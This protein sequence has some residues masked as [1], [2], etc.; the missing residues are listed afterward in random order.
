MDVALKDKENN[1]SNVHE[2]ENTC[3][4]T[5]EEE[6]VG[7]SE[8]KKWLQEQAFAKNHKQSDINNIL[9]QRNSVTNELTQDK[10]KWLQEQAFAKKNNQHTSD[11]SQS[12][13]VSR[14]LTQ[15][16]VKWLQEQAF[17]KI[18]KDNSSTESISHELTQDKVK[19]LQEQAFAK[20][21]TIDVQNQLMS[22]E[23]T[24]DKVKWLQ[25]QAFVSKQHKDE[26][27]SNVSHELTQDKVKW[28]Q[29]EAFGKKD[30]EILEQNTAT[31]SHELTQD[32]VKWLQEKAF[33]NDRRDNDKIHNVLE[34]TS[35]V[36]EINDKDDEDDNDD[37]EDV[38]DEIDEEDTVYE[39]LNDDESSYVDNAD[40]FKDVDNADDINLDGRE[41]NKDLYALLS[42]SKARLAATKEKYLDNDDNDDNDVS[43]DDDSESDCFDDVLSE[44]GISKTC[45]ETLTLVEEDSS[46]TN[47][48]MDNHLEE[49]KADNDSLS[50]P[51]MGQGNYAEI[52]DQP[53]EKHEK[54]KMTN[55]EIRREKNQ[56][57]NKELWALLNY[58]KV[59]LATGS[60]PTASEAKTLGITDDNALSPTHINENDIDTDT[61]NTYDHSDKSDEVEVEEND[62][63]NVD[64]DG[65][66]SFDEEGDE[67]NNDILLRDGS[68]QDNT[69]NSEDA[70]AMAMAAL[71]M[72]S[73]HHVNENSKRIGTDNSLSQKQVLQ[74]MLLAEEASQSGRTEF[75][76]RDNIPFLKTIQV[77]TP[78]KDS[79]LATTSQYSKNGDKKMSLK[80]RTRNFFITTKAKAEMKLSEIKVNIAKA[81]QQ[82][83]QKP[84]SIPPSSPLSPLRDFKERVAK[85][86]KMYEKQND[87][88]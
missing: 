16:K 58:S 84:Q 36:Q 12:T 44:E 22:N 37:D 77:K 48:N 5:T 50:N 46:L 67:N 59:R 69:R 1:D 65:N 7:V 61:D 11:G 85:V 43:F 23:L 15:D 88:N 9:E 78:T 41:T 63:D 53:S 64:D 21:N 68:N 86:D 70:R 29:E 81:D 28:L 13:V 6:T 54:V 24:Q 38:Y 87:S 3:N 10:V 52:I 49:K 25:E 42:A 80:E 82:R 74:S 17:V 62:V 20:N 32:K 47:R 60:T 45:I 27:Y 83:H 2:S 34:E 76:T 35:L 73:S 56:K 40:D 33:H 8:R 57:D 4:A 72:A 19:W 55:N 71:A 26:E 66:L 18:Q 75:A 30:T 51:V 39:S 79:H 14:E 31:V